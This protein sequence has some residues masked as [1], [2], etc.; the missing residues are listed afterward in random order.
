MTAAWRNLCYYYLSI[1]EASFGKFFSMD[2]LRHLSW[3]VLSFTCLGALVGGWLLDRRRRTPRLGC[4]FASSSAIGA[5]I[6][7]ATLLAMSELQHRHMDDDVVT[8]LL[9]VATF[10]ACMCSR[11]DVLIIRFLSSFLN[12]FQACLHILHP[13]LQCSVW[14]SLI[15]TN[16]IALDL[17]LPTMMS[18]NR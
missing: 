11:F 6:M 10:G 18:R 2:F 17:P 3:A 9:V 7:S 13:R 4:V 16:L 12:L 14:S 1:F 8:L 15:I 5:G